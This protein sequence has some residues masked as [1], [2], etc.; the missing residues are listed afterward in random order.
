VS[1]VI[2][3]VSE[4]EQPGSDRR[5]GAVTAGAPGRPRTFDADE[6]LNL[7]VQVFWEKGY[8][9]TSMSDV[10]AATGLNKSS[11]YN[12]FGSK[13]QLF[14]MAL[15]RY[16]GARTQMIANVLDRGSQGLADVELLFD[17]LWAEV[18]ES[19]DHRGCLAINTSTELGQRDE[20]VA[21]IGGQ[22]RS[23]IRGGLSA[24]FSRA[25]D[26]GEIDPAQVGNYTAVM[27]SFILGM[28]VTVRSGASNEEVF[29]QLE[30]ARA[31]LADWRVD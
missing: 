13:D 8:E 20:G 3:S 1:E 30:A 21:T 26:L 22:F 9:A 31:V 27:L 16:I 10:V 18:A 6:I 17:D 23:A 24:A 5:D 2:G 25:A 12:A 15:A 4:V 19:N 28:A 11:L 29:A 7:V 14:D